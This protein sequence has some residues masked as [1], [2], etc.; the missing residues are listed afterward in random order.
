MELLVISEGDEPTKLTAKQRSGSLISSGKNIPGKDIQNKYSITFQHLG[1][2]GYELMLYAP[3]F[4]GRK[5]WIEHIQHQKQVL[6]EKSDVYTQKVL[7][8]RF[9]GPNNRVNSVAPLDGGRKLLYGTD[10]GIFLSDIKGGHTS[11][12][13]LMIKM[14][15]ITQIDVIEEYNTLLA[16]SDKTLYSWSLD[17]LDTVDPMGSERKARKIMSHI[18][19]YRVGLCLGRILVCTVKSG[20]MN[21][22]VRVLEPVD[23]G[24]RGK[25]Q[26][27]LRKLLANQSEGGLKVFKEFY[28]QS[29]IISISFL[30]SKLCVGGAKGFDIVSL[31][32]VETQSLLDPADTSLDFVIRREALKPISIYRIHKDFLLNY[33][34]FSFF[35][36][37]NGW[38]SRSDWIIHWEGLP[39]GFAISYP[40]LIAFEPSFVEIRHIDT[41][42]LVRV[43]TGENIRFLHENTREIMYVFEDENGYDVVVSLDFWEKSKG[44]S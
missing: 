28:I 15:A 11:T 42:E 44:K 8:S 16:L 3:T 1:R 41:A 14:A 5:K 39:Q 6:I 23:P 43:I 36:N 32:R 9:F 12:P 37:R 35:V 38:R 13:Q 10:D 27:A 34:D 25:R 18:N 26:P 21:S 19:F 2:R 4:I 7:M 40:Y 24:P 22:T 29:E 33:S 30:T 17:C 20:S 31:E